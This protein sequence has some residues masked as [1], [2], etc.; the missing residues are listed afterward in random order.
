[1]PSKIKCA[2]T[3]GIK[4]GTGNKVI[5]YHAFMLECRVISEAQGRGIQVSI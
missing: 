3:V 1:M 2:D 5:H 4:S